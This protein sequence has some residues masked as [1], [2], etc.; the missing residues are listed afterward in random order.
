[1][2]LGKPAN[3]KDVENVDWIP[4]QNLQMSSTVTT[5][6]Q[7]AVDDSKQL[8]GRIKTTSSPNNFSIAEIAGI[9]F[10]FR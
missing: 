6:D 7:I 5:V 10:L 2:I 8:L 3:V 1:M 9:F 4:T